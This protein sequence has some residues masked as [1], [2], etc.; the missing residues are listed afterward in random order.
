MSRRPK[1]PEIKLK[2]KQAQLAA[3]AHRECGVFRR[4]LVHVCA[5]PL[6][7]ASGECGLLPA[8]SRRLAD[9]LREP[10]YTFLSDSHA[11]SEYVLHL[12][13]IEFAP[14]FG[15]PDRRCAIKFPNDQEL[16]AAHSNI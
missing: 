14:R 13:M 6:C 5:Y 10:P 7:F 11:V 9:K 8:D 16:T 15:K 4:W 12:E 1:V 2:K 3:D